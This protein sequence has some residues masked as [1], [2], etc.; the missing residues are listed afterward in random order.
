[1]KSTSSP[2]TLTV[3]VRQST[4]RT[5]AIVQVRWT[6]IVLPDGLIKLTVLLDPLVN[7]SSV[8]VMIGTCSAVPSKV[9]GYDLFPLVKLMMLINSVVVIL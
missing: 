3:L 6:T 9:T 4:I 1:M 2:F 5:S 7:E 8:Y